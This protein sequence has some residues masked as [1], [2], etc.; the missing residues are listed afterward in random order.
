MH[1]PL[2]GYAGQAGLPHFGRD[3]YTATSRRVH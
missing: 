3:V 2:L 1:L